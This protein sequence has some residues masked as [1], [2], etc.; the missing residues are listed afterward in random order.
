MLYIDILNDNNK[1]KK[2]KRVLAKYKKKLNYTHLL[3]LTRN[4]VLFLVTYVLIGDFDLDSILIW[5]NTEIKNIA[6]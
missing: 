6:K 5:H 4:T 1:R 3:H 2:R